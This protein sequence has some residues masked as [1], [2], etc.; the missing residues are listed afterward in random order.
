[1]EKLVDF[2]NFA[3]VPLRLVIPQPILRK[4]PLLRTN[5]EERTRVVIAEY[6]GNALDIGCG[7]NV[8]IE[9]YRSIGN[10]GEGVD[11]YPWKDDIV[12]VKDTTC[13]PFETAEFDSVSFVAC[14]NHIPN[15]NM[16][17]VSVKEKALSTGA[18]SPLY[19]PYYPLSR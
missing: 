6:E 11:V 12:I 8:L 4:I 15:R 17:Y 18:S 1:M 7:T 13:L 14:I 3:L 10:K 5:L 19:C 9:Q 2:I 16:I